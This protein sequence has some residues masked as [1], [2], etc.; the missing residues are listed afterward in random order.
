[1]HWLVCAGVA[2]AP[3]LPSAARS[4]VLSASSGLQFQFLL[5]RH[6]PATAHIRDIIR[7]GNIVSHAS[8]FG[9]DTCEINCEL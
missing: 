4:F 9:T 1:M 3:R 6:G 2:D 5:Q 8:L 7:S